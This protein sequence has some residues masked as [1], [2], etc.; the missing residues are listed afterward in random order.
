[1]P[2]KQVPHTMPRPLLTGEKI[3]VQEKG[4]AGRACQKILSWVCCLKFRE[5]QF[6]D[7]LDPL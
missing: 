1:M 4:T 6:M 3:S 5:L 7:H 2:V